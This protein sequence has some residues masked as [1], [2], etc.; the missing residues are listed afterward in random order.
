LHIKT[1][2]F[3]LHGYLP[4]GDCNRAVQQIQAINTLPSTSSTSSIVQIAGYFVSS[5]SCVKGFT[6]SIDP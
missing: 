3:D 4:V 5:G 6:T 2:D 1:Y